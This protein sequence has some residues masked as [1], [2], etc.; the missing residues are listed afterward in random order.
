M[1]I[2][3]PLLVRWL[4][5]EIKWSFPRRKGVLHFTFDDGPNPATTLA[6]LQILKK[7]Q[8]KATFFCS[9]ICVEQYPELVDAIKQE[10]HVVA[11]HGY[12]HVKTYSSTKIIENA[13]KGARVVK[14]DICRV[15]YGILPWRAYWV[16][17][18][19]FRLV[20]WDVMAYDFD[21]TF[22]PQ[23]CIELVKRKVK[24]GSVIVFHDND[25]SG[26]NCLSALPV[27]LEYY[28][29]SGYVFTSVKVD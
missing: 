1:K 27:L 29:K 22:E 9:G 13:I 6:I 10:G 2:Q 4:Y 24:D 5:H 23:D 20:F 15:P 26:R 8:A 21:S 17:K 14:S 19:Q 7:Y 11:N 28:A 25:K 18:K 3:P 12:N 16:L